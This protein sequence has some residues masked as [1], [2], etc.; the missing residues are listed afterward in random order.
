MPTASATKRMSARPNWSAS[1]RG[2]IKVRERADLQLLL[3]LPVQQWT[4]LE[5]AGWA[6]APERDGGSGMPDL[7]WPLQNFLVGGQALLDLD[8]RAIA[9]FLGVTNRSDQDRL[10]ENAEKL[11]KR[12]ASKANAASLLACFRSHDC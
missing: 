7:Y 1:L 9:E 4:P 8:R 3:Q 12:T 10:L 5:V 6:A 2:G 11:R